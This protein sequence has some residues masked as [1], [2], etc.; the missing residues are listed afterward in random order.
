MSSTESVSY[1]ESSC[2]DY[3]PSESGISGDEGTVGKFITSVKKSKKKKVKKK[4]KLDHEGKWNTDD[5][6]WK[7]SDDETYFKAR[8]IKGEYKSCFCNLWKVKIIGV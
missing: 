8:S 5:S 4:I 3:V 1:E 2:S 7:Y 6:D